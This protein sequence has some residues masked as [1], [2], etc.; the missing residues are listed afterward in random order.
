MI[1]A[2]L[3][4][5]AVIALGTP[6]RAA[7]RRKNAPNALCDRCNVRAARRNA[8]AA[9]FAP[10]RVAADFSFPPDLFGLGATPSQAPNAFSLGQRLMSVP[11]SLS[12][13]SAVLASIPS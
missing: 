8:L 6:R 9:R 12:T 11:T 1:R 2:S 10:G 4:A 13:V 3:Y 7:I 5:V